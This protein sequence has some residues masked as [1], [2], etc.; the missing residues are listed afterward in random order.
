MI[1]TPPHRVNARARNQAWLRL[2]ESGFLPR[3]RESW[4][5]LRGGGAPGT[6]VALRAGT[7]RRA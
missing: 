7:S 3:R 2:P 1:R 5:R 6:M 4:A